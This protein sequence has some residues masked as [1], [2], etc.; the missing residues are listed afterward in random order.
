LAFDSDILQVNER[1]FEEVD[2]EDWDAEHEPKSD[3]PPTE[4][5]ASEDV[6]E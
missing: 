3:D 4:P 1:D 6:G 5:S 2:Q